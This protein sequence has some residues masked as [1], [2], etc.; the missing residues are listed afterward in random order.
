M[1]G[2]G[3]A[4]AIPKTQARCAAWL[5]AAMAGSSSPGLPTE[6]SGEL[7]EYTTRLPMTIGSLDKRARCVVP[8]GLVPWRSALSVNVLGVCGTAW[9]GT[10]WHGTLI[11]VKP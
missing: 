10:L 8:C 7:A 4:A 2:G 6:Q 1:S 9:H 11:C 3:Q 5:P